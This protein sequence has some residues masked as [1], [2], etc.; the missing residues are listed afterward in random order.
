MD[1]ISRYHLL[2]IGIF[3]QFLS[4]AFILFS[5]VSYPFEFILIGLAINGASR[6]ILRAG[7]RA[8]YNDS[9]NDEER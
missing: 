9:L 2:S 8:L 1:R 3:A 6:N 7:T 5:F 4:G